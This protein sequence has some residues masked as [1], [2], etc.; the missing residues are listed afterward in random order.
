MVLPYKCVLSSAIL[1]WHRNLPNGQWPKA[2]FTAIISVAGEPMA[3]LR[4]RLNCST[5][6]VLHLG[7]LQQ[8]THRLKLLRKKPTRKTREM[9]TV[10]ETCWGSA[11]QDTEPLLLARLVF[12]AKKL[13]IFVQRCL[14]GST[15]E[16][17]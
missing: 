1:I 12:N 13:F 16:R 4:A 7:T 8:K 5:V 6:P 3:S 15:L 10:M 9:N 17:K 2:K 14:R 11:S